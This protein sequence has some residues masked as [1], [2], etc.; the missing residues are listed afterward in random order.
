MGPPSLIHHVVQSS[1]ELIATGAVHAL[2]ASSPNISRVLFPRPQ[3][4]RARAIQCHELRLP[5]RGP[6][7]SARA[8]SVSNPTGAA[9][10]RWRA[11]QRDQRFTQPDRRQEAPH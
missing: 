8:R 1:D 7:F 11:S 9:T 4:R 2:W 3:G 10:G 6:R 5:R